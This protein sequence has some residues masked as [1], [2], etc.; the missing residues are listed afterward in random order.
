MQN[1]YYALAHEQAA[2][3]R[4]EVRAQLEEL[5]A[6]DAKLE[7]LIGALKDVMPAEAVIAEQAAVDAHAEPHTA[8]HH[9]EE[10]HSGE[11][12]AQESHEHA[13]EHA[14]A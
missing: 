2:N 6:R 8:E 3:E 12:P 4:A 5:L 14:G 10:A 7:K 11:A 13:P 1:N 9:Q